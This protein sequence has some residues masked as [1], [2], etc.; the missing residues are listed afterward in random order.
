MDKYTE[1]Q[2]ITFNTILDDELEMLKLT[3]HDE[4]Q[5]VFTF[6]KKHFAFANCD[7]Q[8]QNYKIKVCRVV[9]GKDLLEKSLL[10]CTHNDVIASQ[11]KVIQDHWTRFENDVSQCSSYNLEILCGDEIIGYCHFICHAMK[12]L[13]ATYMHI[14]EHHRKK[15]VGIWL[16]SVLEDLWFISCGCLRLPIYVAFVEIYSY[17]FLEGFL[18]KIPGQKMDCCNVEG[19]SDDPLLTGVKVLVELPILVGVSYPKKAFK[20]TESF[21]DL[22]IFIN[23]AVNI[24]GNVDYN[25]IREGSKWANQAIHGTKQSKNWN[26]NHPARMWLK[27]DC[28]EMAIPCDFLRTLFDEEKH[29]IPLQIVD[30]PTD[31]FQMISLIFHNGI[32]QS[33]TIRIFFA[34]FYYALS[35]SSKKYLLPT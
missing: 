11:T 26:M 2:K 31:T 19:G 12:Y 13:I 16:W 34:I 18:K 33:Q 15:K 10:I 5:H 8:D 32:V 27:E 28:N 3:F 24:V 25:K 35:R 20:Y 22:K 14:V 7:L 1:F 6:T 4:E 17:S 23:A 30:V 21:N 29:D 9:N